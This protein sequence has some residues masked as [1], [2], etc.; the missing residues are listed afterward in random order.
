MLFSNF[1]HSQCSL[2]LKPNG[3]CSKSPTIYIG[4]ETQYLHNSYF[5]KE[6]VFIDNDL[7]FLA[8]KLLNYTIL[9]KI[10]AFSLFRLAIS[11][12]R[13]SHLRILST[14]KIRKSLTTILGGS[15]LMTFVIDK[16]L[17]YV[18]ST[19]TCLVTRL[20]LHGYKK[21]KWYLKAAIGMLINND[22]TR[23]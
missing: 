13:Y 15:S 23:K 17:I 22:S 1:S 12:K 5:L 18:V 4:L 6:Q 11:D 14:A 10:F 7:I 3:M 9:I 21:V 2:Y 16:F 20:L 8:L 19:G